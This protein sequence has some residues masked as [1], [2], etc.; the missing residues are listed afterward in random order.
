MRI[1]HFVFDFDGTLMCPRTFRIYPGVQSILANLTHLGFSCYV[2]TGRERHSVEDILTDNDLLGYFVALSCGDDAAPKPQVGSLVKLL[3]N[4]H[5]NSVLILGDS[6]H[7]LMGAQAFGA[8]FVAAAWA[9]PAIRVM[10]EQ[11]GV[12]PIFDTVDSFKNYLE[13]VIHV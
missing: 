6:V 12:T 5:A 13:E 3:P 2:W 1:Q 9:S 7:D 8:N 4:V 11:S 10:F